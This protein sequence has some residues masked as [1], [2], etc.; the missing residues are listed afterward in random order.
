MSKGCEHKIHKNEITSDCNTWHNTR[1]FTQTRNLKCNYHEIRLWPIWFAK[2]QKIK[3]IFFSTTIYLFCLSVTVLTAEE[4][5]LR[6]K[7][8]QTNQQPAKSS[9][10]NRDCFLSG[11]GTRGIL[12]AG[13]FGTVS[14]WTH[15]ASI[16]ITSVH[17]LMKQLCF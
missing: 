13:K 14:A 8:K 4:M 3:C 5:S 2:T 1:V 12:M 10:L 9:D 15:S 6:R 16:K 17:T 7:Q 11:G